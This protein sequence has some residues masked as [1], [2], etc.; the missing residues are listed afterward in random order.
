VKETECTNIH[1]NPRRTWPYSFSSTIPVNGTGPASEF[2]S[3]A[4]GA[5]SST[6]FSSLVVDIFQIPNSAFK[7]QRAVGLQEEPKISEK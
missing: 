5:F 1:F 3:D 2:E 7:A 6:N 4:D